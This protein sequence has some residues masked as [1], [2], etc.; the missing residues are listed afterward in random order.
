MEKPMSDFES[1]L[2]SGSNPMEFGQSLTKVC[3]TLPAEMANRLHSIRKMYF[4][5][6]GLDG[7]YQRMN[8]RTVAQ[9]FAEYQRTELKPIA[10]GEMDSVRYEL[11]DAPDRP[12][13]PEQQ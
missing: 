5:A 7:Q 1:L 13:N 10:S 3:Q 9:I 2:I 12:E 4:A 6:Y 11:Y 8:N